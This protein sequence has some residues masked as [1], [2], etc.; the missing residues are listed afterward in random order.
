[1]PISRATDRRVILFIGD[2]KRI[3]NCDSGAIYHS[4]ITMERSLESDQHYLGF[5]LKYICSISKGKYSW[6]YEDEHYGKKS[7]TFID[8]SELKEIDSTMS[9][10]SIYVLPF[11]EDGTLVNAIINKVGIDTV[12][13]WFMSDDSFAA[14]FNGVHMALGNDPAKYIY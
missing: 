5:N 11:D 10:T 4:D 9:G 1:M 6:I 12:E 14:V 13:S 8:F 7:A 2:N 3:D